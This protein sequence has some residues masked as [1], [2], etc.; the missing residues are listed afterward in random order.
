VK[1]IAFESAV[2]ISWPKGPSRVRL[3][4]NEIHV[5]CA[6]L[7]VDKELQ[8][9]LFLQLSD[10]ER[11]RA[12]KFYFDRDRRR[13][14]AC[15]GRQRLIL[16][17]YLNVALGDI[18]FRYSSQG[19]PT[20]DI[21]ESDAAIEFNT[22]NS[23][24]LALFAICT[25]REVGVDIEHV[26]PLSDYEGLAHRFYAPLERKDL[27][28]LPE[29]QRLVAFFNC[30]TRKEAM[31]K[32][33]GTG[34]SFP[35]DQVVVSLLPGDPARLVSLQS[36]SATNENWCLHHLDPADGYVAA[37]ASQGESPQVRQWLWTD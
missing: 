37:L 1:K 11:Q 15:R 20:L 24:K 8:Q 18:K 25:E 28:S 5:W 21:P 26:R 35:L 7:D 6:E 32:A 2:S 36:D 27:A 30:W 19:K 17:R 14:I 16:S 29:Q 9:E 4:Q 31:L 23:S 3:E 12:D 10:D 34:L 33:T 22:S 13:F